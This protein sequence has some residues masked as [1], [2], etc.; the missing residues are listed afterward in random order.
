[1]HINLLHGV[2][3]CHVKL[4]ALV[5]NACCFLKFSLQ[6]H[7]LLMDPRGL[8]LNGGTVPQQATVQRTLFKNAFWEWELLMHTYKPV[9]ILL[10]KVQLLLFKATS[11]C[12]VL[13]VG[14]K[15]YPYLVTRPWSSTVDPDKSVPTFLRSDF[16]TSELCAVTAN[17]LI[18][19]L[20]GQKLCPIYFCGLWCS[21]QDNQRTSV[22]Y[23]FSYTLHLDGF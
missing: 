13:S 19:C 23:H 6:E 12:W 11:I 17:I 2:Q 1:M 18:L 4:P 8:L 21:V 20:K 16:T 10:F 3:N 15:W 14:G 22:C 9:K 7:C 5:W